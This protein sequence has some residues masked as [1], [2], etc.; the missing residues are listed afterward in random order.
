MSREE[1]A[2]VI[3][4][5]F[6]MLLASSNYTYLYMS[7]IKTTNYLYLPMIIL[8][9]IVMLYAVAKMRF[10]IKSMPNLFPNEKLVV[11]HV[12]LFT[13]MTALWVV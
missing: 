3:E 9:N 12:L 6:L 5:I 2:N 13:T 1:Y 11:V 7:D 8:L 10:A 4:V